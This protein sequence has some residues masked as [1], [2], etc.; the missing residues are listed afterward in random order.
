MQP[1]SRVTMAIAP[2]G[3]RAQEPPNASGAALK[4][5]KKKRKR[6]RNDDRKIAGWAGP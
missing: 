6:K 1:G 4:G 2:I 5:Q 3:P